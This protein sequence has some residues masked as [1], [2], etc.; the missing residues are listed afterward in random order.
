MQNREIYS[1]EPNSAASGGA[2]R[3]LPGAFEL[4]CE[5]SLLRPRTINRCADQESVPEEI[6]LTP[7]V[8]EGDREVLYERE[9]L[10]MF[11]ERL[12]FN[13]LLGLLLIPLFQIF[14][15]YLSPS[16]A[17]QTLL[18]HGLMLAVCVLYLLLPNRIQ[19]LVWAR[20]LTVVG[21][22]LLCLGASFV[23]VML[24]QNQ[25][26]TV[27]LT[28]VQLAMLAAHSQI[29]LS[30]VLLPLTLWESLVMALIVTLSLGW[31]SWWAMPIE[32][33]SVQTSQL[34]VLVTTAVFVLCVVHFQAVLRRRAFDA[35]FDLARS[36]AQMQALSMRDAV[37]GGFNRF[38]LQRTLAHELSRATR[39]S[40]P[41]SALM[42][43]LDNFKIVNDNQGHT[44][45]DEVLRAIN[46]ATVLAVRDVDTVARYGGDEFMVVLPETER[47]SALEIAGRIQQLAQEQLQQRFGAGTPCGSVTLSVGVV[48]LHPDE[49]MSPEN[50]IALA[51]ERLYEA[52]RMGKDRIAA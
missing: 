36:A 34:F 45:G 11:R 31:S 26:G 24:S 20:L 49:T 18:P 44:T 2:S 27:A 14:Y 48:T 41:L 15:F 21:Y 25:F 28:G 42:F 29:L 6:L 39:F 13:A 1:A 9:L 12:R 5:S 3:L 22:T 37:T 19:Y 33:G 30:V 10:G 52:K 35:S 4:L 40:H 38:Y 47:E 46:K 51:D 17:Q 16:I 43:D 50:V 23:M 32:S 8:E 7:G